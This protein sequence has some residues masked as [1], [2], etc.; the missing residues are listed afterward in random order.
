MEGRPER[1]RGADATQSMEELLGGSGRLPVGADVGAGPG[2]TDQRRTL[3]E[4]GNA[5]AARRM[6][7]PST[8]NV[9]IVP[10]ALKFEMYHASIHFSLNGHAWRV[11]AVAG[12]AGLE[13][14]FQ[15]NRHCGERLPWQ[16]RTGP[17]Q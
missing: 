12:R 11:A 13:R 5:L 2:G 10:G 4:G 9:A 14:V 16:Q 7:L 6:R 15:A 8:R 3:C 1:I 17:E